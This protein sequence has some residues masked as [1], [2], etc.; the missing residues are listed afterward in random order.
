MVGT[1]KKSREKQIESYKLK[2][3]MHDKTLSLFIFLP[4]GNK[5]SCSIMA[6]PWENVDIL[7]CIQEGIPTPLRHRSAFDCPSSRTVDALGQMIESEKA[8]ASL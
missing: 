8:A 2:L 7:D 1:S 3:W 6:G 4:L 5:I